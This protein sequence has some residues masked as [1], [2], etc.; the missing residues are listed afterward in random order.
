M[1]D[2]NQAEFAES[3]EALTGLDIRDFEEVRFSGLPVMKA[4]FEVES[5]TVRGVT[6]DNDD[7]TD[8]GKRLVVSTK[9]KVLEVQASPDPKVTTETYAGKTHEEAAWINPAD[10]TEGMGR[11]HAFLND[12]GYKGSAKLKDLIEGA[13]NEQ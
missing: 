5:V 11:L 12:I 9:C 7:P 2:N 1:S 8:P 3:I 6:L 13:A 4:V 10:V